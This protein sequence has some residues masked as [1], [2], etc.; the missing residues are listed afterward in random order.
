M[1]NKLYLSDAVRNQLLEN[2]IILDVVNFFKQSSSTSQNIQQ[3]LANYNET[4][5]GDFYNQ[6]GITTEQMFVKLI[7]NFIVNGEKIQHSGND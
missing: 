1:K 2:P 6:R 5:L 3:N 7:N 4:F